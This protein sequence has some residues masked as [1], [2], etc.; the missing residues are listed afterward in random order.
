[1]V[2]VLDAC[3]LNSNFWVFYAATTNVQFALTV[4]DTQNGT[5]KT[6]MNAQGHAATP[7]QDTS[8]FSTCP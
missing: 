6:Y 1:L 7:I 4:T 2:K 5:V 3:G 8:A